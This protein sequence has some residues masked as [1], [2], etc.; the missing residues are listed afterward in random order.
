LKI[1][2]RASFQEYFVQDDFRL[3]DRFTINAGLRYTL[4]FPST[5]ENN[6]A[7]VFD[8]DA[9]QLEYLGRDGN[10]RSARRLH[11]VN[12]GPRFGIV[13]RLTDRTVVRSG[14]AMVWIEQAG[15]TTPLT[16]PV[17]P[18]LQAVSQ[19][20]LDNIVPAFIL[21]NGPQVEPIPLTPDAGLGQGVF[22]VDRNLGSGYVQQWNLS[23]QRELRASMASRT[24]S[25]RLACGTLPAGR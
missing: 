12:L 9:E 22:S 7:A 4:N 5:E 3:T 25:W 18:F 23:F 2:N 6:Q 15:I 8:L 24:C 13:G 21:E 19:R 11:G 17:F 14:Y 16:T 20:T 1:R 10:P